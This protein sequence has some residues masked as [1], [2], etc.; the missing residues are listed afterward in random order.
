MSALPELFDAPAASAMTGCYLAKVVSV[1]DQANL[2][3]VQVRLH[4]YDGVPG[5][6]GPLWARV[7][8]PFAGAKRGAFM[9]PDVGD[10]VVI[11]FI[12]GDSRFPIVVGSLWNGAT[13]APDQLG[14]Q[15]DKIDRWTIVGK[16]GTRIAIVEETAGEATITLST[17]GKVTAT[18]TQTSGGKVEI[19]A[20]GNTVTMD[21]Q[22]VTV[23]AAALVKVDAPQVEVKALYLKVSAVMS[24]FSGFVKCALLQTNMVISKAYTPGAGNMW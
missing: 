13:A 18:L 24:D 4:G 9:L 5:Q 11:S 20:A 7:A 8:V 14:G 12:S 3:R 22:G 16:A 10:E 15:G 2:N 21:T 1:K 23:K 19:K 6:D 17:P